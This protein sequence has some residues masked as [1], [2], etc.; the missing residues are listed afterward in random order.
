MIVNS[1]SYFESTL[2]EDGGHR[3]TAAYKM[4]KRTGRDVMVPIH[5]FVSDFQ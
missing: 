4:F 5:K 2:L 1:I 3:I